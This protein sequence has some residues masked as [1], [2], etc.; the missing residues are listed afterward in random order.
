MFQTLY[1]SHTAEEKLLQRTISYQQKG[2][3]FICIFEILS[4]FKCVHW[5][6]VAAEKL[7]PS[8][9]TPKVSLLTIC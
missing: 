3:K 2:P 1:R 4:Y 5:L 7:Q 9:Q 8:D 6:P